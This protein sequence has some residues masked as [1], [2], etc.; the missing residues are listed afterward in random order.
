M[1]YLTGNCRDR[2]HKSEGIMEE[3]RNCWEIMSCGRERDGANVDEFGKCPTFKEGLG[4][5]CWIIAGTFCVGVVQGTYAQKERNCMLCEVYSY[6]HRINGK[7]GNE[8]AEQ[9]PGEESKYSAILLNM[10]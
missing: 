7:Y 1:P 10:L 8:I 9:F 3:L 6:Y 5:S 2:D 4:H